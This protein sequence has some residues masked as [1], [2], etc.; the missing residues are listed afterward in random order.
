[1]GCVGSKRHATLDAESVGKLAGPTVLVLEMYSGQ[2]TWNGAHRFSG[3]TENQLVGKT[4]GDLFSLEKD[5]EIRRVAVFT[6][7]LN[8][9]RYRFRWEVY[10][11]NIYVGVCLTEADRIEDDVSTVQK[12]AALMGE[13][14]TK[15]LEHIPSHMFEPFRLLVMLADSMSKRLDDS[16][17][18][19][20]LV[21]VVNAVRSQEKNPIV[22]QS[23]SSAEQLMDELSARVRDLYDAESVTF[24][25]N[26]E[27]VDS[28]AMYVMDRRAIV[29]VLYNL[30]SNAFKFTP[31]EGTVRLI[32]RRIESRSFRH[33]IQFVVE[34][35][36]P[37]L[38]DDI[39]DDLFPNEDTVQRGLNTF[40][41]Q[42]S[43]TQILSNPHAS[44]GI[45]L[46]T[47]S[48]LLRSMQSR[49]ECSV[50][51]L[52]G[53]RMDFTL[54]LTPYQLDS[55]MGRV[56]VEL[57]PRIYNL[58]KDCPVTI[59]CSDE[60]RTN[61][62]VSTLHTFGFEEVTVL[63]TGEE[64]IRACLGDERPPE[65]M[66]LDYT[67]DM[68]SAS[69]RM[70]LGE[71]T[72]TVCFMMSDKSDKDDPAVIDRT[73]LQSIAGVFTNYFETRAERSP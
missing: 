43:A 1:M 2:V 55:S 31:D 52:G 34:D 23:L 37:G 38:P 8:G 3:V 70:I 57:A 36:G 51:G 12:Y 65:I 62:L 45:G 19:D 4:L 46:L 13:H 24:E 63:K 10:F 72:H 32:V 33:M 67:T 21:D 22:T 11:P 26:V 68:S 25:P 50:S 40:V 15:Y 60:V 35:S 17:S 41:R 53:T 42:R 16:T 71:I 69:L 30:L 6:H 39:V 66:M 29:T 20:V 56:S 58:R 5:D 44:M 27:N 18:Q 14:R 59:V 54:C 49:L 48:H 73:S 9:A 7:E 28:Q 64:C 47:S 61:D